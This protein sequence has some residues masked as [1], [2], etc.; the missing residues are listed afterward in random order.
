MKNMIEIGSTIKSKRLSLN[1]SMDYVANKAGITRATL[2]SIEKGQGNYSIQSL[3]NVMDV[4]DLTISVDGT[5]NK[6]KR[7]RA[8][9]TNTLLDK[10]INRFI[11]MCVEQYAAFSNQN[12][13]VVYSKLSQKGIIDELTNDYVD[14]H[15]MS[16]VW[17]NDY[18]H[19]L[20]GE[21]A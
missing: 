6:Q 21:N 12:S 8:T 16:N 17:I 20:L 10:K 19:D 14:L 15:S 18:I 11:I 5:P 2:W 1:L 13:N 3:L 4:L 9:R 7:N